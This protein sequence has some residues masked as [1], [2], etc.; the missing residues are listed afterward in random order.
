M[1][2]K[3]SRLNK[4]VDDIIR[5]QLE[6]ESEVLQSEAVDVS[7][8]VSRTNVNRSESSESL[9][10]ASESE[11]DNGDPRSDSQFNR[12]TTVID[13]SKKRKKHTVVTGEQ[14]A[15]LANE[16]GKA[17][18]NYIYASGTAA[19]LKQGDNFFEI[20]DINRKFRQDD[21]VVESLRPPYAARISKDDQ[22]RVLDWER[23]RL[24]ATRQ[25]RKNN[26]YKFAE[27][28]AGFTNTVLEQYYDNSAEG[29]IASQL[30]V[31]PNYFDAEDLAGGSAF[32]KS[33]APVDEEYDEDQTEAQE[34]TKGSRNLEDL[35][36]EA[37][38]FSKIQSI[39]DPQTR[40]VFLR[41][42]SSMLG[43]QRLLTRRKSM[44]QETRYIEK[45][46]VIGLMF[47]TPMLSAHMDEAISLIHRQ[48]PHLREA[49]VSAFI[50]NDEAR[51]AL[52]KMVASLINKTRFMAPTRWYRAENIVY[53]LSSIERL[54]NLFDRNFAY[55]RDR[56]LVYEIGQEKTREYQSF[57]PTE[58]RSFQVS[59]RRKE[60]Q[61]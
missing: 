29:N 21:N 13:K 10:L 11:F 33:G 25:I 35:E 58:R 17:S 47:L 20:D 55:D 6:G 30:E 19:E 26:A 54:R 16:H 45:P 38:L 24:E 22:R 61:W 57:S 36:Q 9:N 48:S 32:A 34:S 23:R 28:V 18:D 14:E 59:K 46:D 44:Q 39:Q 8:Q 7:E 4:D 43:R 42:M 40:E 31:G 51:V 5:F 2:R 52:A 27:L 49:D 1:S 3:S 15:D 50:N 12:F 37:A 41:E 53:S 60:I 56:N